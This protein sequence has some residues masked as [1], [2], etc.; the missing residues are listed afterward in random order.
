LSATG[1]QQWIAFNK[2]LFSKQHDV[3]STVNSLNGDDVMT[4]KSI[5]AIS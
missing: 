5:I 1:D 2:H 4:T 3:H